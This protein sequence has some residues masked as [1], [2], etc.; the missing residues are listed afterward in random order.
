MPVYTLNMYFKFLFVFLFINL[1]INQILFAKEENNRLQVV[2]IDAGHGGQDPGALGKLAKEK[3]IVLSVAL[4]VGKL[5]NKHY[6]DVKII[7]TRSEDVF[8]PLHERAEIAN[9][10]KAD[11][12]ISIHANA[13]KNHSIFGAE[14]YTM[15][16]HTNEKNME[17]AKKENSVIILEKDYTTHYEGYDPNSPESF[18]I[19]SLLQ[20][21]YMGQSLDFAAV[22]QQNFEN[23]AQRADRGVRQAGFLVL[24]KTTMP[25]VLIELGF[26]T[27]EKEEIYLASE[28]GQDELAYSIFKS[29]SD[30]KNK[31]ESKSVFTLKKQE[32]EKKLN[33]SENEKYLTTS[34]DSVVYKIQ[35]FSSKQKMERNHPD[36]KKCKKIKGYTGIDELK[37]NDIYKYTI[38]QSVSYN[39]IL[40][41]SR[42][43]KKVFPDAFIIA[44]K[45]GK[46]VNLAEAKTK[47]N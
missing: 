14:T 45:N 34:N 9:K 30:Y 21:T 2:V 43:V 8:I 18:I 13:N 11:L 12:F 6:D 28:K 31:I 20:N 25:S 16:L 19:F 36:I 35:I 1:N 15:G 47:T 44:L 26:I 4:K 42:E 22:V 3:D 5:I 38:G 32:T 27:N 33:D 40:D 23:Q 7:Y 39:E 37:F 24:W 29:F 46:I 10:N 17:V 41:L